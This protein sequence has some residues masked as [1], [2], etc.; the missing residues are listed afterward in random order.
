MPWPLF[1]PGKDPIPVVQEAEWAPGPVGKSRLPPEFDPRTV[2]PL[3]R[4]YAD[5]AA[6]PTEDLVI[7]SLPIN[8]SI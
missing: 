8:L 4:R 6:R 5:Y 3:A 1:T 7:Q 2:Q